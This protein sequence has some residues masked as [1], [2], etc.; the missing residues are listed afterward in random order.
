MQEAGISMV[1]ELDVPVPL[2]Y[3]TVPAPGGGVRIPFYSV[4]FERPTS[5]EA[6]LA[7]V[8]A[9]FSL[10]EQIE[11]MITGGIIWW[12]CRPIVEPTKGGYRALMRVGTSPELP[13]DFWRQLTWNPDAA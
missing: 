7:A 9:H 2:P 8:N 10:M 13:A 1:L 6:H 12:A 5:D 3:L 4:Q 11:Q